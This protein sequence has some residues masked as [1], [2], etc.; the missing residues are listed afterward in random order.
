MKVLVIGGGM[1]GLT[2][3]IISAAN[4]NNVTVAER[5]PR[6]GKKIGMTGNGKCNIGNACVDA[7][8]Y[9]NSPLVS[10]ILSTI[11]IREYKSFLTSCGILTYEDAEHRMYPLSDSAASVVDC[12]RY[13]LERLGGTMLCNT[14]VT[15]CTKVAQGYE[16]KMGDTIQFFDRVVLA[17]GSGSQAPEPNLDGIVDNSLFT[18]RY[19]SLVPVRIA[20][21]N[22][23]LNGIRLKA[24]VTLLKDGKAV[25][26]QSGELL[27]K[28]YGL[29]GICIFNL[30]AI[31]ARDQVTGGRSRYTFVVDLVPHL[32]EQ[33]LV[34]I[35][36]ARLKTKDKLFYGIL[37][38][39]V[40]ECVVRSCSNLSDPLELA[41]TAKNFVF[42]FEKLLD[43]SM[44]QITAG[45]IDDKYIN[46]ST[47]ALNNGIVALGEVLNVDGICGGYNLF[48]AAASALYTFSEDER[49]CAYHK[50]W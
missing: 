1:S 12:L 16:V 18:K 40:A 27:F 5:N 17:C 10:N 31:I 7:T 23:I 22:G 24:N 47:L 50:P 45:G 14:T 33:A 42:Q 46:P 28:D 48:F 8:C 21:M 6:V 49:L 15:S 11:S 3:A 43:W 32:D 25:A 39:K 38:N 30:S 20:S 34:S 37:H 36:K 19:P 44:S 29:S 9:N 35:I 13:R 26:R 4:G 41:R 2:Y